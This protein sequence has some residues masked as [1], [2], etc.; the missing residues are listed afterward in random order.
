MRMYVIEGTSSE[1]G[2]IISKI[3]SESMISAVVNSRGGEIR[4]KASASNGEGPNA[5]VTESFAKRVLTRL[6]LSEPMKKVLQTLLDANGEWVEGSKLHKVSGYTPAQF[7]G[8][9][10]AF[11][12]RMAHTHGY[13]EEAHFWDWK[14]AEDGSGWIYRLPES[15]LKVLR[16]ENI[17]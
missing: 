2:D 7:A 17:L 11:G 12:R 3:S 1:I 8:L 4:P 13:D 16:E 14:E 5:F 6:K 9:M 15:V 10:G